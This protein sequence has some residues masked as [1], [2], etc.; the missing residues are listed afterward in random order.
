MTR[1]L[2]FAYNPASQ[3][4]TRSATN[5]AY[6]SNT[7]YAVNRSHS[8]DGL[9]DRGGRKAGRLERAYARARACRP[10]PQLRQ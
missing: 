5:D 1:T 3:I 8:R 4:A 10:G 6:A 2:A 7:A 9:D